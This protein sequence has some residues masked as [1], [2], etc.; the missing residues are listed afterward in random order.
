MTI[1]E[2]LLARIAE[3]EAAA[4]AVKPLGSVYD[5]GG[6]QL[7]EVLYVSRQRFSSSD[8]RARSDQDAEATGLLGRYDPT[9]VLVECEAKRRIV[10]D[11]KHLDEAGPGAL[12]AHAEWVCRA[13]SSIYAGHPD[14][15]D[16]WRS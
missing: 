16:E 4:R 3:D 12:T 10:E 14:Y 7:E 5:M 2:F 11:Y 9:R 1:T 13:L 6:K 15:R 8:G